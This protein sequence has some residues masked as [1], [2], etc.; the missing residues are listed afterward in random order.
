MQDGRSGG[1]HG[2]VFDAPAHD[3]W[4]PLPLAGDVD[5]EAAAL[6]H[7]VAGFDAA[8]ELAE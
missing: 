5:Q 7:R 8:V 1:E 4:L 6:V 3:R 2:F